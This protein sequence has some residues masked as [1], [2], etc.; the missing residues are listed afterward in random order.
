M[1]QGFSLILF[2]CVC[3][4]VGHLLLEIQVTWVFMY[5]LIIQ[6]FEALVEEHF[7]RCSHSFLLACKNYMNGASV[8]TLKSN[9]RTPD[10]QSSSTGFRIMLTKLFPLLV[11]AFSEKGIDCLEFI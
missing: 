10:T 11:S 2:V 1:G 5:F 4:C 6:H 7:A 9:Q 8:G 3:V